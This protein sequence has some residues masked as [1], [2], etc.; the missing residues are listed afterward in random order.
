MPRD[1]VRAALH[2]L[3]IVGA[4]LAL[5]VGA[6]LAGTY[7]GPWMQRSQAAQ[8]VTSL[9]VPANS[10]ADLV[11]HPPDPGKTVELLAYFSGAGGLP[12]EGGAQRHAILCDQPFQPDLSVLGRTEPNALPD[13][14]PWLAAAAAPGAPALGQL[15]YRARLRGRLQTAADG[16]RVFVIER[17]VRTYA[18]RPPGPPW[19]ATDYPTWARAGPADA[20]YSVPRP[21]GWGVEEVEEG[22]LELRAPQW[23]QSP[24]TV[25]VHPGETHYDPYDPAAAPP[26]LRGRRW[27]V[28]AQA[29]AT[30]GR[31]AGSQGLWGYRVEHDA[32]PGERALSV[33]YSGHGKTYELSVRYGLG[34][35]APQPVLTGYSAIVA[36]F[37][38]DAPPGPTPTPPVR[39]ALG[40][41]PLLSEVEAVDAACGCLNGEIESFVAQL[42][43]EVE[44]RRLAPQPVAF[45]GHYD[46]IWILTV[47]TPRAE[48]THVLRLYLDASSGRE[49]FREEIE[50]GVAPTP[51]PGRLWPPVPTEAER[52]EAIGRDARWIEVILASQTLIAWEGGVPVRRM[53][54]S[55]GVAR[56]PTVTGEF[57]VY[58]KMVSGP[59]RGPDY[60]L[61]A[62]PHIMYFHESYGLHG[63]YWHTSF[64]TPMSHGCVNLSLSDAAWLFD[65]ASPQVPPDAS[66]VQ[67]TPCNPGT[68]VVV[69]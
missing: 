25:R 41:G 55:S 12:P 34:F 39:Q 10:V 48:R 46:G 8:F 17:V 50:P 64:G 54:I 4:A 66:M 26:L 61:P 60:Y 35:D 69:H 3:A 53:R 29:A 44:A 18:R 22:A 14:A 45:T 40:G 42:V 47:W 49:L 28:F 51:S 23:P 37:S 67:A 15:P 43:P 52:R 32:P 59:M 30:G 6:G 19:A 16:A 33:L 13:G 21:P 57:R 20:G 7:L 68:L 2:V 11:A 24:V 56:Y 9:I 27:S 38:F 63:A 58:L 1:Y 62:V 65:W 31:D 36:G 5:A